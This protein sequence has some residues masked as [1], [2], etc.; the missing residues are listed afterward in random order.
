MVFFPVAKGKANDNSV[1]HNRKTNKNEETLSAP[2]SSKPLR[3]VFPLKSPARE[4]KIHRKGAT[5]LPF[6]VQMG[7]GGKKRSKGGTLK[8]SQVPVIR[9]GHYC[10]RR[11]IRKFLRFIC[12][13][14]A[15]HRVLATPHRERPA[16]ATWALANLARIDG[17]TNRQTH[18]SPFAS[19]PRRSPNGRRAQLR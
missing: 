14:E 7:R 10:G 3:G 18:F 9:S 11:E 12:G 5:P 2:P 1:D 15:T 8:C 16:S 13:R 4:D 19:R 17:S 6:I